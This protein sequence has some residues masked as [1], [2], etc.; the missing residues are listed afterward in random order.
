MLL[1]LLALF[2]QKRFAQL[3]VA[4]LH[5]FLHSRNMQRLVL[6]ATVFISRCQPQCRRQ[7]YLIAA[8]PYILP[9]AYLPTAYCTFAA[10]LFA[11]L[12][13]RHCLFL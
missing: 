7:R 1:R 4:Q 10:C 13:L 9:F 2:R 6:R 8:R 12:H 3:H 11:Y 5:I